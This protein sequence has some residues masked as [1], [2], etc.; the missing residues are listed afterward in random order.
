MIDNQIKIFYNKKVSYSIN[1]NEE[2]SQILKV[3][4]GVSFQDVEKALK[5]GNLIKDI[6][7]FN[8]VKYSHQNLLRATAFS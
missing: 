2:K 4:R 5:K 7:H 1:F 6:K 8:K 3:M